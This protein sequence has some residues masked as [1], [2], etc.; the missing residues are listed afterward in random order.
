MVL[1]RVNHLQSLASA[2]G[3][4]M[5]LSSVHLFRGNS[6]RALNAHDG[7]FIIGTVAGLEAVMF[8]RIASPRSHLLLIHAWHTC[9]SLARAAAAR[10]SHGSAIKATARL[11]CLLLP[12]AEEAIWRED[13]WSHRAEVVVRD[14]AHMHGILHTLAAAC[15]RERAGSALALLGIRLHHQVLQRGV[16]QRGRLVSDDLLRL[17]IKARRLLWP[18][19]RLR[20]WRVGRLGVSARCDG[21]VLLLDRIENLLLLLLVA[22][23]LQVR[24]RFWLLLDLHGSLRLQH[25]IRNWHLLGVLLNEGLRRLKLLY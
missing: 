20:G 15:K 2:K 17:D 11:L 25:V 13:R 4:A 8:G 12:L 19:L 18:G 7:N 21:Q 6:A 16:R 22:F 14:V 23:V 3:L 10:L 24:D 1:Q 9:K 5:Q